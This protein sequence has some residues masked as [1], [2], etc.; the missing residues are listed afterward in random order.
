[1]LKKTTESPYVADLTTVS[2]IYVYCDIVQPQIVGD[3]SAQLLKSIP[4]EGKFGD[5]IAKTFTNIQYVPIRTKSFEAVEV[6]LRNDTGDPVPFERGKVVITLH[7]RKHSYF[8]EMSNP[9]LRYYLDQQGHGMT[10][11]RGSPWQIG[12]GQ[13]GYG[14]GG[15]FR[16]VARAVMPMVKSG[17]KALGNIALKSGANFVGDVLASKNV[18]EAAKARTLEAANVAKRKAVNKLMNQ[19]GSGKRGSKQ[20]AKKTTKK[21]KAFTST[22]RSK[23]TKKRRTTFVSKDIFG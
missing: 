7:F 23:Q 9:Y 16:S 6:L 13:M 22:A 19:T 15:L 8:T 3:T 2:T 4:A 1:M 12:H 17:A 5:L 14:L 21:R 10:V 18:K 11:F 20:A